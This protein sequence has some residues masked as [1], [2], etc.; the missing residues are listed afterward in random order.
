MLISGQN[1]WPDSQNRQIFKHDCELTTYCRN[2]NST[3]FKDNICMHVV[4][5][6]IFQ[7]I[8]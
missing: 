1:G 8:I 5:E 7:N 6:Q 3:Q 2:M 4:N